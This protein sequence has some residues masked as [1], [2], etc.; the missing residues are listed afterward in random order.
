M[1]SPIDLLSPEDL[2]YRLTAAGLDHAAGNDCDLSSELRLD[3]VMFGGIV[4]CGHIL[5]VHRLG[6][7]F[8]MFR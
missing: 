8:A 1:I 7:Y 2:S 4:H 3:Y 6:K 5:I